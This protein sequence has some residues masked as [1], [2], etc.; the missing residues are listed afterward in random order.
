[1]VELY[2]RTQ[3]CKSRIKLRHCRVVY[4]RKKRLKMLGSNFNAKQALGQTNIIL[5]SDDRNYC[6]KARVI[7]YP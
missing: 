2:T 4:C 7:N 3:R 1:M 5:S 6:K